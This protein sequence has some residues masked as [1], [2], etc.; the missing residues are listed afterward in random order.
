MLSVWNGK[1]GGL[2][3]VHTPSE[4][5]AWPADEDIDLSSEDI[6]SED[7]LSPVTKANPKNKYE[8]RVLRMAAAKKRVSGRGH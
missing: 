1:H 3:D 4:H 5:G 6:D 8:K 2:A 7:N